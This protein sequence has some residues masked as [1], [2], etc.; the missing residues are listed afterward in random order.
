MLERK[1]GGKGGVVFLQQP[2]P[3]QG[4]LCTQQQHTHSHHRLARLLETKTRLGE[5]QLHT[6]FSIG[7]AQDPKEK[8]EGY[9]GVVRGSYSQA[10]RSADHRLRVKV[11]PEKQHPSVDRVAVCALSNW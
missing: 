4:P 11:M 5:S 9:L 7:E 8:E 2:V 6:R 1:K 3:D 10:R